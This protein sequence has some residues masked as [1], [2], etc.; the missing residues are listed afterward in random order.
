MRFF[1]EFDGFIF[2]FNSLGEYLQFLAGRILAVIIIIG[3]ILLAL[4]LI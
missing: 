1:K 2:E 3:V 4:W